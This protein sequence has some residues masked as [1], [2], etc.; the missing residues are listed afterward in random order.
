M[1]YASLTGTAITLATAQSVLRN[2]IASQ[3]KRVTIDLIQKSVSEHFN[4]REQ[5]LK[6]CGVPTRS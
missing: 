4:L 2:I 5:D 3:E 1:A 6:S